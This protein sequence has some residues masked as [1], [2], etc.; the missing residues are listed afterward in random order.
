MPSAFTRALGFAA[1][2]SCL[3]TCQVDAG[4]SDPQE[5]TQIERG[6]YL[7]VLS[8]CGGCHT[9][10]G[11]KPFAGGRAI[12]TPFGNVISP[13]VTPD[14]ETGIGAWSDKQFDAAVRRGIGRTGAHLYPAMPYN[15]YTMMSHDDVLA[16]R[17][18]LN[19]L[20]PVRNTRDTNTLPF[21]FNI[22]SVMAVWNALYFRAGDYKPNPA[23]SAEWN[24]GKFIV[25]GPAHC[26]AC[27]TPK[28]QL[29][30]DRADQYLE[31]ANLQGWSAPDITNAR[32]TGLG[33]WTTDDIASYLKSGHNRFTA[34]TGPMAEAVELSTSQMTD[35]DRTAIAIYLKSLPGK[36]HA[37]GLAPIDAKV[38]TAGG[39]IYRDQ[40]SACHGIE[41]KGV[42]YLF[43][44]LVDSTM[45]RAKD[46]TTVIRMVLRGA[47]SV[48]TRGEPTAP[49][50]PSY[51][52]QLDDRQVADV[53]S[54]VRNSGGSPAATVD[55][56]DV[57]RVR[58]E[59]TARSD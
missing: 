10:P 11:G 43:P 22:R 52:W 38:M 33:N 24:R 41:G 7:S 28:T 42:P 18:Y 57:A 44:S 51:G 4:A 15:A 36:E 54:Y 9:A 31:G 47:R 23:K 13:N 58:S 19:S 34:A 29:G 48:G 35:D 30:G 17:A 26:G 8:D 20:E 21:P 59:T 2:L 37:S 39:A 45:V 56:S 46:P 40:C 6:R 14:L 3:A 32:A 1:L 50:M 53:L 25:D 55:P 12:E 16:I 49:G 5:F 27:H